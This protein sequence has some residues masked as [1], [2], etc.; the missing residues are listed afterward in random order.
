MTLKGVLD[1]VSRVLHPARARNLVDKATRSV[2]EKA[3]EYIARHRSEFVS[4]A[5][6]EAERFIAEQ[7]ALIEAKIDEKVA[8]IERKIDEQIEKEVKSKLK[9]LIY[10]L[11]AVIA[12]SLVSLAYLYFKRQA[13]L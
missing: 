1:R 3:D 13:G 10:T 12:M 9:V 2:Q 11:L 6:T 8:E 4:H 7:V 5:R